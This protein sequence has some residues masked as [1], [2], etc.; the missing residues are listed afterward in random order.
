[1]I[2][3]DFFTTWSPMADWV[4]DAGGCFSGSLATW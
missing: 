1:M 4:R 3:R 2:G